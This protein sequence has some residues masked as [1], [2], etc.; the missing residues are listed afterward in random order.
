MIIYYRRL[1]YPEKSCIYN[2]FVNNSYR[3]II[4]RWK[5]SNHKL[6]IETCKYCHPVV[7][8][9]NGVCTI[10]NILEDEDHVIFVCPAYQ[11]VRNNS[12]RLHS[13]NS[14]NHSLF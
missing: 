6:N 8:R 5:L 7:Q 11:T 14:D 4:T 9:V 2:M 3:K 13:T 12:H 1:L 10:S